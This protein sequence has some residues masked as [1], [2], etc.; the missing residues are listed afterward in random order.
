MKTKLSVNLLHVEIDTELNF[1]FKIA[2]IGI[3]AP[4]HLNALTRLMKIKAFEEKKNL[5]NVYF[6]SNLNSSPLVL[7]FSHAESS[8]EIEAREKKSTSFSLSEKN[9]KKPVK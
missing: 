5:I 1:N 7:M 8:R 4:N 3:S 2:N 6:Y 9:L